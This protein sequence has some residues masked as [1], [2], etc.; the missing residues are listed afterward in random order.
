MSENRSVLPPRSQLDNPDQQK[1]T[2]YKKMG[3]S[4]AAIGAGV[5]LPLADHHGVVVD[6]KAMALFPDSGAAFELELGYVFGL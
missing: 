1:L 4:F 5:Y 3:L 6:L 2:V